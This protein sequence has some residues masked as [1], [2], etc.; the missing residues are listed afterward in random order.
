MLNL[1]G[2]KVPPP[3]AWYGSLGMPAQKSTSSLER[4]TMSV[5]NSPRV[6]SEGW[7]KLVISNGGRERCRSS[8]T[9][10][11]LPPYVNGKTLN[12]VNGRG[13]LGV[14]ISDRSWHVVNSS[15]IPLKTRRVGE[16]CTLNLPGAQTSSHWCGVVVRKEGFQLKNRPRHLTMVQN[17]EVHHQKPSGA[18][19]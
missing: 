4:S 18:E 5:I 7:T 11:E 13:T 16:R 3:L 8:Y 17:D 2:I 6:S 19:Q 1:S 9:L 12:H 15:P 10:L 14:K